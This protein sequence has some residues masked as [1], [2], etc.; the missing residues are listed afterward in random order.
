M[1]RCVGSRLGRRLAYSR[2]IPALVLLSQNALI[3]PQQQCSRNVSL[4]RGIVGTPVFMSAAAEKALADDSL[5]IATGPE[6]E[7]L[8]AEQKGSKRFDLEPPRGPFGTKEAP[9][10]VQSQFD[11]RIVGCSGGVGDD[12]HDVVW[13]KLKKG[14]VYEC[15]ICSQ[16]FQ[17][18]E[19]SW[20]VE[21]RA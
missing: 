16:V 11:E 1:L 7:E 5:G 2:A 6:R 9:A 14:E 13:F 4:L 8:E 15:S 17:Q 19:V 21:S 3:L 18:V 12:E 20:D 10:L